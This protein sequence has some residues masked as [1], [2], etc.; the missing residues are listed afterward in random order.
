[1]PGE[2]LRAVAEP[3]GADVW[4]GV[5][6]DRAAPLRRRRCGRRPNPIPRSFDVVRRARG[7]PAHERAR[8]LQPARLLV[9]RASS[10]RAAWRSAQIGSTSGHGLG[11][12]HRPHL[13]RPA[14]ARTGSSPPTCWRE[15]TR[16]QVDGP[17]PDPRRGGHLRPRLPAH[18]R[19]AAARAQPAQLRPLR[20]R[21]RARLRRPRRRRR[22]RLRHEPRHPPLAEHP[23]PGP[24]R[25]RLR[26]PRSAAG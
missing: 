16:P 6:A 2:R 4:F 1:M 18:H 26:L 14:R 3:L 19:P 23:Q 5:P 20:H 21:R 7:R 11:V 12:G 25:R 10:T 17:L 24:H 15:A 22:V 8:P 13:R 9:G